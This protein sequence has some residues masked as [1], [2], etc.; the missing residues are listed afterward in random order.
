MK[1][2]EMSKEQLAT[3][4]EACQPVPLIA[5]HCGQVKSVQERVNG[6]W[7]ALGK[8]MGFISSTVRPCGKGDRIF[9]ADEVED[10]EN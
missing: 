1:E 8:E 10:N 2:F 6:A 7:G 9:T 5:I 3:L 4:M